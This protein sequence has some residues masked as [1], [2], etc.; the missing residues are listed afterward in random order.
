[1]FRRSRWISW[2]WLSEMFSAM[3]CMTQP[4][5]GNRADTSSLM[6]VFGAIA[7]SSSAPSMLSWSQIVTRFMP[8]AVA[9]S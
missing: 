2:C 7:A 3:A 4:S 8:R 6:K 5:S 9:R 1:M